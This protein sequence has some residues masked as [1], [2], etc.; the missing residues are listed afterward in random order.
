MIKMTVEELLIFLTLLRKYAK[1]Q[2]EFP[3]R[4]EYVETI[5]KPL[6][7]D[8]KEHGRLVDYDR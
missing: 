3:V 7:N 6:M 2:S 5:L 1:W 8:I 4:H